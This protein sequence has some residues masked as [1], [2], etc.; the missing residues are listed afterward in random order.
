MQQEKDKRSEQIR[1]GLLHRR[2]SGFRNVPS[3]E[4]NNLESNLFKN[5]PRKS[6]KSKK[7][8]RETILIELLPNRAFPSTITSSKVPYFAVFLLLLLFLFVLF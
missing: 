6:P 1:Y 7:E 4:N 8:Q 2:K 3:L 5:L